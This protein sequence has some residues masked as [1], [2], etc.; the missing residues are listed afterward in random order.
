MNV[1]SQV[2]PRTLPPTAFT[3]TVADFCGREFK[4]KRP[5]L[6]EVLFVRDQISLTGR[7]RH[8]KTTLL[9]NLGLAGA[10]GEPDYLGFRIPAPFTTVAF[11]LEDD[12]GEIRDK[13]VKMLRGRTTDRFHLYIRQDFL[14]R[15]IEIG[16]T[17]KFQDFVRS[18]C[19][20]VRPDLII[21][22]NLGML[23]DAAYN[24][25]AKIHKLME[26][27]FQLTQRYNCAVLIAAHPRKGAP[28]RKDSFGNFDDEDFLLETKPDV[29]FEECMGASHFVNSTGSLWGI[30]R[31]NEETVILVGS[32]RV[33]GQNYTSRVEKGDDDWFRLSVDQLSHAFR[34]CVNSQKRDAAFTAI[35]SLSPGFSWNEA[36]AAAENSLSSK[37]SFS[38]FFKEMLRVGIVVISG[39]S[40]YSVAYKPPKKGKQF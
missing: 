25:A 24:D 2:S 34:N 5:L 22:D 14:Q 32:Q 9:I 38:A 21:L 30:E 18:A 16:L 27:T 20:R 17:K 11:L 12:G 15:G 4:E 19:E 39:D 28:P 36:H 3:Q 31:K 26:F 1:T 37:A 13:L 7:R 40:R 8:G 6:E 23:I 35:A 33:T 29:F 10:F